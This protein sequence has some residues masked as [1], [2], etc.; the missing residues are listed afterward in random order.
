MSLFDVIMRD[1]QMY[2]YM[3]RYAKEYDKLM[4]HCSQWCQK[5]LMSYSSCRYHYQQSVWVW[6]PTTLE[7]SSLLLLEIY[8]WQVMALVWRIKY[9][10]DCS[11]FTTTTTHCSPSSTGMC[12]Y[13]PKENIH[14]NI[15]NTTHGNK[16]QQK[17]IQI[18]DY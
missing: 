2:M 14:F 17:V 18:F 10:E 9:N 12:I 16:S 15:Q 3:Y 11:N 5:T 6:G 4:D 13:K 8:Y 7:Q 1:C